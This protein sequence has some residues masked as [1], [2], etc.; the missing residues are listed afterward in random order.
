MDK[1]QEHL[2]IAPEVQR[3]LLD[4]KPV[5]ALDSAAIAY[6][7]PYPQNLETACQMETILYQEKAVPAVVTVLDGKLRIGLNRAEL[8]H[9][10]RQGTALRKASRRD[11]PVLVSR[12]GNG[13]TTVAATMI[14]AALVGIRVFATGSIGGVHRRAEQTM[15]ISADLDELGRTATLVVCGGVKSVL[16]LGRTLEYLETKGVPV[17]GFKTDELP[18]FYTRHSGFQADY[19]ADSPAEVAQIFSI[20]ENLGLRGGMLV[21]NPVPEAYSLEAHHISTCIDSALAEAEQS[22]ISGKELSLFLRN[23]IAQMTNGQSLAATVQLMY[24]NARLA[25]Q[26]AQQYSML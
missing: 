16:D 22:N 24:N 26:I 23:R 2:A 6:G 14:L 13:A 12:G 18:A 10:A 15:D 11:L 25:A 19:R 5:V 4:G 17:V 9:L 7:L 3:A 8:E 21:A 20:K 1:L